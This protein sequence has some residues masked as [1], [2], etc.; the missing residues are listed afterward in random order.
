M[1]T[2]SAGSPISHSGQTLSRA[3]TFQ[4]AIDPSPEQKILLAKCAGAR[5]FTVNHHL[6]RVRANLDARLVERD[7]L[8]A[9]GDPCEPSTPSLSWSA[10]SFINEFNAWKN[11][12]SA[13]S[14]VSGDGI[15]GLAWRHELPNDVF[16]CASVD[17]ARALENFA[18]SRRGERGGAPVGFPRFQARGK[19]TPSF[20]LRNRATPGRSPSSQSIRFS[21]SAHLRLPRFGPV[22]VFGPTRKV[23]R[24]IDGG[25]FHIYSAT[26]TQRAGRWT[27]SLTGA[28]AKLHQ[29]ER[30][31]TNRHAVPVGVDRGIIS[32]CVAADANGV[33]FESFEGV[34]TLK[35][36]QASLKAANQALA[37]TTPGS[38]GRQRARARLA[39][40]HR[41]VA[42]TRRHLVHQA[43]KALVDQAQFL[44]IEDLNV[45]GMVRNRHLSRSISDA[46]MGELSRQ[47]LYKA[48]WH[49]VEVRIA[50]RFFPSSKTCSGCGVVRSDLDL[51]TRTYS[52]GACGLVIDRDLNAA[53]NLARWRPM[54]PSAVTLV[55][56]RVPLLSTA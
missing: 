10:F 27:V 3:V 17:A 19:V 7:A 33:F 52:C 39:K 43:S 20:R 51:S 50:D 37:R 24:M 53:I 45:A 34:T 22:K 32:L 41:K 13:D 1:A 49:G 4:F 21:D 5:R 30:S 14:P 23:R 42:N 31:R 38:K 48:N 44:V 54:E 46:A 47:L 9:S 29:A 8:S 36:T 18:A 26:L 40:T 16:E 55:P 28:A 6:A 12:R 2:T 15:R 56:T 25:R 35:Q 11:G